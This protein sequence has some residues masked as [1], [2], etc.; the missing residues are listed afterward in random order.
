MVRFFFDL[1]RNGDSPTCDEEGSL[2][3]GLSAARIEAARCL[4][5]FAKE[6]VESRELE[7]RVGV[8]VNTGQCLKRRLP[9]R[10]PA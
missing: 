9:S 10:S 2:M 8:I 6:V 4:A 3:E 5:D 7:N 1:K